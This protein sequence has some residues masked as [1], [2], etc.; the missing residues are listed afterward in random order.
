MSG[1]IVY[2]ET[3]ACKPTLWILLGEL[4]M[5]SYVLL[6]CTELPKD[7]HKEPNANRKIL[8]GHLMRFRGWVTEVSTY[9]CCKGIILSWYSVAIVTICCAIVFVG[10]LLLFYGLEL[11]DS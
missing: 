7:I 2:A 4:Q 10:W 5:D 8:A 9:M 6:W 11:V 1:P 3:D